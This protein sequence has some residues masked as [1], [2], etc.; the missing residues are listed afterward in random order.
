MWIPIHTATPT[1]WRG[2]ISFRTGWEGRRATTSGPLA[3]RVIAR[4]AAR[5]SARVQTNGG[6]RGGHGSNFLRRPRQ[7]HVTRQPHRE[8]RRS[9]GR[10]RFERALVRDDDLL[11]DIE[12]EPEISL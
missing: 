8:G 12:T 10:A 3:C 4:K 2:I 1:R 6:R 7:Q 11:R 5:R 9:A